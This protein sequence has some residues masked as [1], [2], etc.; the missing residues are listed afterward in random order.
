MDSAPAGAGRAPR[1]AP[2]E[3]LRSATS[4]G[5]SKLACF[6]RFVRRRNMRHWRMSALSPSTLYRGMGGCDLRAGVTAHEDAPRRGYPAKAPLCIVRA[7][8][9]N[10]AFRIPNYAL[11]RRLSITDRRFFHK[12]ISTAAAGVV[13]PTRRR[14]GPLPESCIEEWIN[15]ATPREVKKGKESCGSASPQ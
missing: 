11:T 4:I 1:P 2:R 15:C 9:L 5:A 12:Y 13:M 7:H 6:G 10:S 14:M 3:G 8:K